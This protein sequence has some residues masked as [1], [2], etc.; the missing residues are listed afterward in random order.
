MYAA[1]YGADTIAYFSHVD[2]DKISLAVI[3]SI[4]VFSDVLSLAS[5]VSA[6]TVIDFGGGD[7]LTMKNVDKATLVA[8]DFLFTQTIDSFGSTKLVQVDRTYFLYPV[9]GSSGPQLK[10]GGVAVVTGQFGAW[11]PLGAEQAGSGYKVVWQFGS[12]YQ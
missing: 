8:S 11:T 3:G 9:S 12:A 10:R 2:G 7:T 5:Q 6:D 4:D 1:G